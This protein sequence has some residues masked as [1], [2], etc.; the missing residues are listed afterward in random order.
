MADGLVDLAFSAISDEDKSR[1]RRKGYDLDRIVR[2]LLEL[3]GEVLE[4][5]DEDDGVIFRIWIR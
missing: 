1:L 4:I 3:K 2:Q 5:Y